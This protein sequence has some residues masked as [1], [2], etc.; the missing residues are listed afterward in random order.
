VREEVIAA[1]KERTDSEERLREAEDR[2]REAEQRADEAEHRAVE[3]ATKIVPTAG[4]ASSGSCV[5]G[6]AGP[7]FTAEQ[8]QKQIDEKVHALS[9][10]LHAIYKKKHI[11]K[12]AGLKKGFEAKTREKTSELQSRVSELERRNDELQ[13]KIDGTLSGVQVLPPNLTATGATDR[14]AELEKLKQQSA[15]IERQKAELAGR[16]SELRT[17]R[18]EFATLMKELERERVEKGELV[19]AVDEMLALQADVSTMTPAEASSAVEDFKKSIGIGATRPSGL[20]GPATQSGLTRPG[21]GMGIPQPGGSRIGA[22]A[23]LSRS[24]S[25]GKSRMMSNIERMGGRSVQ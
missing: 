1:E 23:G 16:D 21:F 6:N 8:V 22:P 20:R 24:T 19:A 25:G 7:L 5:D 17:A 3:A 10:E 14:E 12:V 9:T 13:S 18:T 15:L 4:A 11:T 2:A